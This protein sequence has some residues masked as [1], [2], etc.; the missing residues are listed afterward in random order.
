[1]NNFRF[2]EAQNFTVS[3]NTTESEIQLKRATTGAE[4]AKAF[5][6]HNEGQNQCAESFNLKLY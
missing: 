5:Q 6:R 3:D 1:M 2:Y 4:I